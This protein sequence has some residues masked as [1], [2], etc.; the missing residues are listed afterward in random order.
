[1]GVLRVLGRTPEML[2]EGFGSESDRMW[3]AVKQTEEARMENRLWEAR[4]QV[5]GH[6]GRCGTVVALG[7]R[8]GSGHRRAARF[9]GGGGPSQGTGWRAHRA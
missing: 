5:R 9:H 7:V 6:P 2:Q 4:V 1:M 8:A 3:F